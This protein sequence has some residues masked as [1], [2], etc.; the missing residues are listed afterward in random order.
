MATDTSSDVP[1]GKVSCLLCRGFITYKDSDRT[2]FKDHMSNE[3]DVK[4]DSDVILAISVMSASD[5]A[6]IVK[7][8]LK[9]LNEISNNQL[10]TPGDLLIPQLVSK[11]ATLQTQVQQPT[12]N[13][14]Q[15]TPGAGS[16]RGRPQSA[17]RGRYS[18]QPNFIRQPTT[19]GPQQLQNAQQF[20]KVL[21]QPTSSQQ[22]NLNKP[23]PDNIP[24]HLGVSISRID[25]RVNCTICK[26]VLP[27]SEALTEHMQAEHL[28]KFRGLV[29]AKPTD[30]SN[31]R[32]SL[33]ESG[34]YGSELPALAPPVYQNTPP[35]QQFAH[36]PQQFLQNK[37]LRT[38]GPSNSPVMHK[39]NG[40]FQQVNN[41]SKP[42]IGLASS[43]P[44]QTKPLPKPMNK[45]QKT[46]V[47]LQK[48]SP[49]PE[50][51]IKCKVCDEYVKKPLFEKH[52]ST[53]SDTQETNTGADDGLSVAGKVPSSSTPSLK[54]DAS[55]VVD[56]VDLGDSDEESS[57]SSI[58]KKVVGNTIQCPAC[59]RKL[60]SNMAL[61]MHLN[62]KHPVKSESDTEKLLA[63]ETDEPSNGDTQEKIK[64]EVQSMET[65]QLLDNLVNFLNDS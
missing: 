48:E 46:I 60:A 63:E 20:N 27:N 44:G 65:L 34:R 57:T 40:N 18:Q 33:P 26:I 45:S 42:A 5:K 43:N 39:S 22:P 17:G 30:K 37:R 8:S 49:K 28:S 19:N 16:Q 47:P 38:V 59:D 13:P 36:Q 61:K 50:I 2:R 58:D 64:N 11:S 32:Q 53:H 3:H 12:S 4:Y 23:L 51:V 54:K 41:R 1:K 24:K 14:L 25:P 9:R 21:Q 62:L 6:H 15:R 56:F 31:K 52:M 29:I 10:P 55:K 7:S 35:R